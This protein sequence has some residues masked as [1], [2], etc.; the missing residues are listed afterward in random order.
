MTLTRQYVVGNYKVDL[1]ISELR[2]VVECD[3]FGHQAYNKQKEELCDFVRFNPNA[4]GFDISEVL[5]KII[6]YWCDYQ[7]TLSKSNS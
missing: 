5:A 1:Y 4:T 6:H 2:L 3:E 7:K